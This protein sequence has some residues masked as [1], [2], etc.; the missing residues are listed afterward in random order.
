MQ[1]LITQAVKL[2][3]N[4]GVVSLPTE[5]V[6]SLSADARNDAAVQKIYQLKGRRQDNPLALLI[7][8]V[9]MAEK[10]VNFNEF[11]KILITQFCPGA[12]TLV[13][14]KKSN[15]GI[16]KFVNE[17]LTTLAVRMPAHA[18]T[19]AILNACNFPVIGTSANPSGLPCV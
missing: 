6:Y 12:L 5:T 19:L 7:G 14:Q 1:V 10:M 15:T 4:S 9:D 18:I 8:S 3:A 11:A 13:L 2:L 17:D 16:S